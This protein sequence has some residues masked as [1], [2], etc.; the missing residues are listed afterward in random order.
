VAREMADKSPMLLTYL[1]R[2]EGWTPASEIAEHLGVSTRTVRSY[3]TAIKVAAAP[4]DVIHSSP[5]GY[6][7]NRDAHAEFA[8]RDRS[9][10]VAGTPRERV[11]FLV[12]RL[13][14]A[15]V[16]LDVHDLADSLFVSSSTIEADLRQVRSLAREAGL[17]LVR[18]G[19]H[20]R[21]DGPDAGH[22]RIVSRL[23]SDEQAHGLVDLRRVQEAFGI[24]DLSGFKTDVMA[25]LERQG[26]AINEFGLDRVLL[27][28]AIAV[29]R[30]RG[31][32]L[33]DD[34]PEPDDAVA[35]DLDRLVVE[36]FGT[37]LPAGELTALTTLLTTRAGTRLTPRDEV[38]EHV[39]VVR[40]IV[41]R[42]QEEFLVDLD[43]D[44][45]LTR[46]GAHVGNLVIRAR[47]GVGNPNPLART[48]KSSY[49]LT[50]ELAV[51][52]AA[53]IQRE[54]TITIGDDEIAYIALHIGSH[55]ERRATHGERLTCVLV[56]PGYHDIAELLERR[57]LPALGDDVVID[58][59][60]TRTDVDPADLRADLVISTVPWDV[61]PA[62]VVIVQPLPTDA[63]LD[64]VRGAITRIRRQR[65][66]RAIT[67][68]LLLY[69]DDALFFR[70]LEE[71]DAES[72]IRVLGERMRERGI[73]DDDYLVG[74]LDRE[75]I[76]STAF[77][78]WLAVPH[79]LTMS[80]KRT[81][82]AIALYENPIPWGD[83]TVQVVALVAF[84][85]KDRASFQTV[86]EQFVEVFS[87]RADV[88]R[89]LRASTD[90][91]AYIDEL[92]RL[93]DE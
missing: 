48:I 88:Q 43:D 33:A 37:R 12:T 38:G 40:R 50:Y 32:S 39:G 79:A 83:A 62:N 36:R 65:R 18:E 73:I 91:P 17:E 41:D 14:H 13:T 57:I 72:V 47:D 58:R 9:S 75:R 81:A 86:F 25:V 60:L 64:A 11:T 3:V 77:T 8:A 1:S 23:F 2:S 68:E 7:L 46:L 21:L 82:I 10:D 4:L 56:S 35:S 5:D 49:P 44:A 87:D 51:F 22:R 70:D 74:V 71:R 90:F 34:A 67:D 55:L 54:F 69:F 31:S 52:V 84:S 76:S 61:R 19:D 80:A 66:R 20:V 92:V 26:Y 93:I 16:E 15:G 53:E 28:T 45:F 63:D 42:A 78:E 30:S 24:D 89:L 85:A 6:R 27:H 59:V 29:E